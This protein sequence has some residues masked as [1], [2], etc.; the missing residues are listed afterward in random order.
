MTRKERIAELDLIRSFAFLAVVYQHVIGI[1]MRKP[2]IDEHTA[3]MYGMLFHFL[4]FAVPAFIFMT[5]LVLF[6]NYYDRISYPTFIR[7]RVVEILIP[8]T[9]WTAVY[10]ALQP[11]PWGGKDPLWVMMKSFLTGTA[12]YHLW[13][14]VMIFQFYLLYPLWQSV[15]RAL[16][17]WASSKIRFTV[18]IGM[19]SLLYG[20]FMWFSSRYIPAHAFRF[21]VT[22]LDT[23]WIKYR[24]R[25]AFYY[26][27]Y[28]LMGGLAAVTLATFRQTIQRRWLWI[29]TSFVLLYV[30]IGYELFRDS[31][32]GMIN[33][34]VATSL[35]PSMFLYTVAQL[36]LVYGA[37]LWLGKWKGS[38]WFALL[39]KYSYGAYLMH[40]LVL[41]YVMKGLNALQVFHNSLAGSLVAFVLCSILSF[42][43][44][45]GL[46]KLP[47]GAWIVGAAEKK[48]KVSSGQTKDL[49]YAG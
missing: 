19:M 18:A 16:R 30:Y 13:F 39:G 49:P 48:R 26:F 38:K 3:I 40:A 46:G 41:T 44:S 21:D 20:G 4:K 8:Y 42:A 34:N 1:Y 24:D 32:H 5:G 22:L 15:F 23:Y 47:F 17:K 10:L 14:V 43:I 7:K 28:F 37:A 35:K 12:S 36:L 11:N 33:L 31:G 27:F 45:Y 25:N 29:C 9:I 6:Y 2:G